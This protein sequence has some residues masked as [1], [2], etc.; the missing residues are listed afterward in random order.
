MR[1]FDAERRYLYDLNKQH[2]VDNSY[3]HELYSEIL[4]A[5]SLVLD[6]ASQVV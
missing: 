1:A 2:M 5:E 3:I 6:P 4:V